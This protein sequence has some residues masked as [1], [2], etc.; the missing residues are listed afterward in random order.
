[1]TML[2]TCPRRVPRAAVELQRRLCETPTL[3]RVGLPS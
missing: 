1:M 2:L 3:M